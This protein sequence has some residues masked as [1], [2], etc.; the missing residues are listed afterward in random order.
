VLQ[1]CLWLT[2][3]E[4]KE[5]VSYW[6]SFWRKGRKQ[7]KHRFVDPRIDFESPIRHRR[8]IKVLD[9]GCG[10][11][12]RAIHFHESA[13]MHVGIDSSRGAIEYAHREFG[14]TYEN[15]EFVVADLEYLPFRQDVFDF[16]VFSEVLEHILEQK[17]KIVMQ[18]FLHVIS[19]KGELFLTTPNGMFVQILIKKI[20]HYLSRGRLSSSI[21]QH[22]YDHPMFPG[23]L[24]KLLKNTG[25]TVILYKTDTY[26]MPYTLYKAPKFLLF[27]VVQLIRAVPSLSL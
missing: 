17:R 7:I 5:G 8:N 21:S 15:V 14:K 25:W 19:P 26:V 2:E 11:G 23:S 12:F 10:K 4:R 13:L 27:A 1:Y 16:V 20:L 6:D 3:M 24:T 18:G 22:K 9:A